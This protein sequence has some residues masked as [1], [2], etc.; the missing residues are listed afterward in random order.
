MIMVWVDL[1]LCL[2]WGRWS[3]SCKQNLFTTQ[4][5]FPFAYMFNQAQEPELPAPPDSHTLQ[6]AAGDRRQQSHAGEPKQTLWL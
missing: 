5:T 6:R 3:C 4:I 1:G 2:P